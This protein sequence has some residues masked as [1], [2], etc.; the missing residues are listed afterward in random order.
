MSPSNDP[1]RR[2]E[3]HRISDRKR[4]GNRPWHPGGPGRPPAWWLKQ[5]REKGGASVEPQCKPSKGPMRAE[6]DWDGEIGVCRACGTANGPTS[7]PP[8]VEEHAEPAQPSARPGRGGHRKATREQRLGLGVGFPPS[9]PARRPANGKGHSNPKAATKPKANPHALAVT[10]R[11][12]PQAV[13]AHVV[14]QPKG[15]RVLDAAITE[16][17]TKRELLD[18]VIGDLRKAARLLGA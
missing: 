15:P 16:L 18:Q 9:E 7:P 6:H 12:A 2:R 8:A 3:A 5:Q 4:S 13:V 14:E 17:E 1:E 10:R 11:P